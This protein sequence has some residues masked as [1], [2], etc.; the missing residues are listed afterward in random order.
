MKQVNVRKRNNDQDTIQKMKDVLESNGIPNYYYHVGGYAEECVCLERTDKGW[1]VYTGERGN[2]YDAM[3]YSD[4]FSAC[5]RVL[6]KVAESDEQFQKMQNEY[7]RLIREASSG[8]KTVY[9]NYI[10]CPQERLRSQSKGA[11]PILYAGR[12]LSGMVVH[13]KS[14]AILSK[15]TFS[16]NSGKTKNIYR[17]KKATKTGK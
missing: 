9:L 17:T 1:E 16:S 14:G 12:K 3:T 4:V 15:K 2:R 8:S 10:V 6:D 5:K 13:A 7:L 11:L